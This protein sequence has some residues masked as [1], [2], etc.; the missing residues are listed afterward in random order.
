M[1]TSTGSA[2][3]LVA[4]FEAITRNLETDREQI[5]QLDRDDGDTGDN[6]AANFRLVTNTLSQTVQRQGEQ[7]DLGAALAQA[8]QVLRNDGRG[9]TAPMY[10]EG[11]GDAAQRLSGKQSF[12]LEDLI[13]LLEGLSGGVQRAQGGKPGEGSLLDVL[14]PGALTYLHGKRDGQSELEAILSALLSV[15]RGSFNTAGSEQGH[16][17]AS[18]R[19][20]KGEIDPGAAG[21]ASLLEGLFGALLQSALKN[22]GAQADAAGAQRFPGPSTLPDQT[23]ARQPAQSDPMGSV[24]DMIG[25]LF[26]R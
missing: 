14:I 8:S 7:A 24:L 10:A 16:G 1:S 12:Q 3:S 11:L 22:Q 5:N 6:M 18:D 21:A 2:Q 20:T 13:P 23:P 4:L 25:G 17:R 19:N 15:R 26:R 9:A